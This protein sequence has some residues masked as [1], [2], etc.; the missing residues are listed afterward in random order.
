MVALVLIHTYMY[1]RNLY[2]WKRV[3]INCTFIFEFSPGSELH[4]E[5]VLLVCTALTTVLIGAV[6]MHLSIHS[7]L[8]HA[9]ASASVVLDKS[10]I[11]YL[12]RCWI[13]Y[14]QRTVS[15]SRAKVLI[16]VSIFVRADKVVMFWKFMGMFLDMFL[17][18]LELAMFFLL[19]LYADVEI[20]W[21]RPDFIFGRSGSWC[22][23]HVACRG[24]NQ[25]GICSKPSQ[26]HPLGIGRC[27]SITGVVLLFD[28]IRCA[29]R[30]GSVETFS[31][32][33]V[34]GWCPVLII[35]CWIDTDTNFI[36][37][38]LRY[39]ISCNPRCICNFRTLLLR[40]AHNTFTTS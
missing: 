34:Y 37:M 20:L 27:N 11:L 10:E 40:C 1:G 38:L 28:H 23:N 4:C 16:M 29:L 32:S 3:R 7:M 30:I 9:Q 13:R 17:G 8:F 15:I 24:L 35:V 14:R 31:D 5:E 33:T 2:M 6:V 21:I 36:N 26:R 22:V 19:W 25:G 18:Y 39:H 12:G